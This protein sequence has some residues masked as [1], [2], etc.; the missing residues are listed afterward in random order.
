[1]Y[2][3]GHKFGSVTLSMHFSQARPP[4]KPAGVAAS[5]AA[6]EAP[7]AREE[8]PS[9]EELLVFDPSAK[10]THASL[11]LPRSLIFRVYRTYLVAGK[12]TSLTFTSTLLINA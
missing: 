9:D 2:Q 11:Q 4:I 6:Q 12:D 8:R 3:L 10:L 1:L 7:S 5:R